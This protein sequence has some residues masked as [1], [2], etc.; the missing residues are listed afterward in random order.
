MKNSANPTPHTEI[1]FDNMPQALAKV[2]DDV[3]V[4]RNEL[5]EIKKN[6]EPKTPAEYLTRN[7]VAEMLS[8]DISSVHNWTKKGKLIPYGIA[9]RVYYKR[10]E[11]EAALLPFG[12][13]NG[14]S[15]L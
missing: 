11:V 3:S 15:E 7:D 1:T 4:I 14:G 12:K 9:N 13:N 6:F 5:T 10:S 2:W 8:C